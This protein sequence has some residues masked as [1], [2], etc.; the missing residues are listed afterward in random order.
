MNKDDLIL[1]VLTAALFFTTLAMCMPGIIRHFETVYENSITTGD[2]AEAVSP[3][4]TQKEDPNET[5]AAET[6]EDQSEDEKHKNQNYDSENHRDKESGEALGTEHPADS[7][8]GHSPERNG[9]D[10][11]VSAEMKEGD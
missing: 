7:A 9:N 6:S 4:R 11:S 5:A 1:T 10:T 2:S 8:S 3:E